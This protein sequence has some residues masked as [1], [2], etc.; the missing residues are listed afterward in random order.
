MASK[1][2]ELRD[3]PGDELHAR[4]D[5]GKEELFNL[6]FQLATGQLDNPER[7]KVVRHEVARIAT[8][9]REREI[10]EELD[11]YA[12]AQAGPAAGEAEE[13]TE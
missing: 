2:A 12:A 8:V 10:E 5:A 11:A 6:R 7:I 9:L 13:A 4:I 1:A 3:L